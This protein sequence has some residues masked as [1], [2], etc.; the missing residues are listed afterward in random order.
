MSSAIFSRE[1][2]TIG[3]ILGTT[4]RLYFANFVPI[5]LIGLFAFLP[6]ALVLFG[7]A[8]VQPSDPSG[9]MMLVMLGFLGMIITFPAGWAGM[10]YGVFQAALGKPLDVGECVTIGFKRLG[11]TIGVALLSWFLTILAFF[12]LIIPGIIVSVMLSLAIPVAAV[13]PVGVTESLRRSAK[14]TQGLRMLLFGVLLMLGLLNWLCSIFGL[15]LAGAPMLS[16]AWSMLT[17]V[18]LGAIGIVASGVMY[19][20]AR[21]HKESIG[22]EEIAAVFE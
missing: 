17:T 4:F 16:F 7:S 5:M 21:A 2:P 20:A 6:F 12:A 19:F 1:R 22:T 11:R 9:A 8:M 14:L 15:V 13:E 18:V 3:S 10:L